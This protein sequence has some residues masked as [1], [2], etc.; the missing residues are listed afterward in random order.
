MTSRLWIAVWVCFA[1]AG[2]PGVSARVVGGTVAGLASKKDGRMELTG[3]DSLIFLGDG[4]K[5]SIPFDNIHTLEYGQRVTRRYAEA[6]LISPVLLLAKSRKH[7]VTVGYMDE[8]GSRQA[9]VFQLGKG[10][11]RAVLAGLEA[12]TGRRVEFQ[13]E[14]ARKSGKG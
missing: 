8:Q 1:V 5:L 14:E 11:I 13:D 6:I 3:K 4:V 2:E 12:K 7:F 9:L 10:D